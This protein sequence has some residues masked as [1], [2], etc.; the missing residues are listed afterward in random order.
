MGPRAHDVVDD[1][2]QLEEHEG[3]PGGVEVDEDGAPPALSVRQGVGLELAQLVDGGD[4]ADRRHR[5]KQPLEHLVLHDRL[6]DAPRGDVLEH[7]VEH[8]DVDVDA[9]RVH[10]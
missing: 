9:H 3:V 10:T 8:R 7:V 6:R 2:A 5:G 4:L 1:A